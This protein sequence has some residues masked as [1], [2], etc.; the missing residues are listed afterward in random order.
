MPVTKFEKDVLAALRLPACYQRWGHCL[1]YRVLSP[2]GERVARALVHCHKHRTEDTP[3]KYADILLAIRREGEPNEQLVELLSI[4]GQNGGPPS[5]VQAQIA[6]EVFEAGV[7]D[8]LMVAAMTQ[9][10]TKKI[11]LDSLINLLRK[12]RPSYDAVREFD[13]AA[14]SKE[15]ATA[16]T[17]E[18]PWPEINI[19]LEGG[20]RVRELGMIMALA[21]AGKT[22]TLINLV[23]QALKT[24]WTV[25][26]ITAAD[27][28]YGGISARC[29][30]CWLGIASSQVRE[31]TA[32]LTKA[33]KDWADAG[34]KLLISDYTNRLCSMLD[35][36]RD[37][38]DVRKKHPKLAVFIDRL[39][40]AMPLRK[41][42]NPVSEITSN[43]QYARILAGRYVVPVWVDSQASL[44]EGRQDDGWVDITRGSGARVGKAKVVDLSIGV[45][46]SP[47]D[48][49]TLRL[50]LAGRREIQQRKHEVRVDLVSG[51]MRE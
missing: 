20:I 42:E 12:T 37:I 46:Q 6:D 45:G 17:L 31:D 10:Q 27:I 8:D 25:L 34:G 19:Q 22:R 43:Y 49:N 36:E 39:E 38:E 30:A 11:D 44:P 50:M 13:P 47:E 33:Q 5:E 15:F 29:A 7:L 16:L 23:C 14:V 18:T 4:I 32:A 26:Y 24:G 35:I 41:T 3:I 48:D 9:Q 51:R 2:A 28:G 40:E 21:K 1:P